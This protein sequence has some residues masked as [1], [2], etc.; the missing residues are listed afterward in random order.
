VPAGRVARK[1]MQTPRGI[2]RLPCVE[3]RQRDVD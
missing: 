3:L 2:T 1:R